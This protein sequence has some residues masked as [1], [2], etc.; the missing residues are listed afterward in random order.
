MRLRLNAL[1]VPVV[2]VFLYGANAEPPAPA[3]ELYPP[4]YLP[5][6]NRANVLLSAGQ[7]QDAAK[8]YSEAIDMAPNDYLLYYKRATA[9][10]SM[11]RHPQALEDFDRVL[12][13]TSNS[14]EKAH[15]LKA[16]IHAK[17]GRFA[18]ARDSLKRY[19]VKDDPEVREVL[20]GV[21]EAEMAAKKA[22]Q[23]MK[24][25]LWQACVEAATTALHTASHSLQLRQQRANCAIAAGDI[26]GAVGDLT[27][28]THLTS[29][30]TTLLMKI[31]RLAYFL[32]PY[33]PSSS[34]TAMSALKQCLHY[35]PDSKQCLPAHRLVKAFDKVFKKLDDALQAENWALVIKLLATDG[36][37]SRYEEALTTHVNPPALDLPPY[38]PLRPASKT[39]PRREHI[40]RSLCRAYTN[41]KQFDKGEA[42]CSDLL[43]MDG[44]DG[45]AD[46]LVG[47]GEALLKREEWEEAV[48]VFEK[49]FEASGR[50]SREI[51]QRL[52]RAQKL[53]KQSRQK[54]YYKVLDV[55]R[56]A[57]L[58][59]I[60]KAF[61]RAAMKAHPDKGGSEAKMAAV[62]EAYEVLSNPELRQRFDNGDDPNDPMAGQGGN[63][64]QGGF[65]GGFP[66][67]HPFQFFTGGGGGGGG[68][69]PGGFQFHFSPPGHHGRGH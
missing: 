11:N 4:G 46:A 12:N 21:S 64:F 20:F 62:N 5:L 31:F 49:A 23:A 40:L 26:E 41:T 67:G 58:K 18:A 47:K 13:L 17:D 51:H 45:D 15:L 38:I 33:D 6:V 8:A 9:Y 25:K 50:S 48:R 28:L 14:F 16:R 63:P 24:A 29:P 19:K 39:S 68:G 22:T 7:F 60:K 32:M 69:F 56:D 36:F 10:Y 61:R 43:E 3:G 34:T 35:D 53:L 52:Q 37:V 54:D 66:G 27:R 65:P 1:L 30:T 44:L 2:S 59:T 55:P 57:D 42:Y